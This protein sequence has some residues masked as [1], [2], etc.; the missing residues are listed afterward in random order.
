MKRIQILRLHTKKIKQLQ[1]FLQNHWKKNH[2]FVK[3]KDFLIWQHKKGSFL[4]YVIAKLCNK[5]V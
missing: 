1:Y 2:I 5:I 3:N 4:T